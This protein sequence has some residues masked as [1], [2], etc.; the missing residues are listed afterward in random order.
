MGI[1]RMT[2]FLSN[3]DNIKEVLLFPAMKP[4]EEA[5]HH[6]REN[7]AAVAAHP[8]TAAAAAAMLEA[9]IC[10]GVGS[11]RP[12][13]DESNSILSR[14]LPQL[15]EKLPQLQSAGAPVVLSYSSQVVAGKNY[16]LKL[17]FGSSQIVH[18]RVFRSLQDQVTLHSLQENKSVADE[19][20]YF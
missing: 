15:Q 12:A 14:V 3:T 16:F 13:D 6:A 17:Q 1:D 7:A 4:Q 11:A 5:P 20:A 18:A 2:M 9:P 10:G 19:I 8:A